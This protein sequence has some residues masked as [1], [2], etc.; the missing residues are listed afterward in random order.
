M[1]D[2]EKD[3]LRDDELVS[4]PYPYFAALRNRWPVQTAI[5]SH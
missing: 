3:F 1:S 4:D 2:A 5:D